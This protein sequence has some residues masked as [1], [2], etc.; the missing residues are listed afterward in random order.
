M[1]TKPNI[2]NDTN[3]LELNTLALP[4][5]G[6]YVAVSVRQECDE[7]YNTTETSSRRQIVRGD[8]ANIYDKFNDNKETEYDGIHS[9]GETYRVNDNGFYGS[10]NKTSDDKD[11]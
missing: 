2:T 5:P 9:R 4:D 1:D 6:E 10:V 7:T 8:T 3:D 11:F